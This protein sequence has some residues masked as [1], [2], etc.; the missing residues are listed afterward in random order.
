M[1]VTG[2]KDGMF[3]FKNLQETTGFLPAAFS[4]RKCVDRV[5]L[6]LGV[7]FSKLVLCLLYLDLKFFANPV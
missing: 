7:G 6:F 5:V 4:L 3:V 1:P 2:L